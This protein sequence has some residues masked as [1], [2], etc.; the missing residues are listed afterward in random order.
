[1]PSISST[2]IAGTDRA[3]QIDEKVMSAIAAVWGMITDYGDPSS[4][5]VTI[6][7]HLFEDLA[8]IGQPGV[9]R[10]SGSTDENG[11]RIHTATGEEYWL[12]V[13][14]TCTLGGMDSQAAIVISKRTDGGAL[15]D[16]G[17]TY[18]V[19]AAISADTIYHVDAEI[20]NLSVTLSDIDDAIAANQSDI[21]DNAAA[22]L[23]IGVPGVVS[24]GGLGKVGDDFGIDPDNFENTPVAGDVIEYDGARADW[25]TPALQGH[26]SGRFNYTD[27]DLVY[28]DFTCLFNQEELIQLTDPLVSAGVSR[29]SMA[30]TSGQ[31]DVAS[32]GVYE[33]VFSPTFMGTDWSDLTGSGHFCTLKIVHNS[34]IYA[35]DYF[36][37][38]EVLGGQSFTI[39]ALIPVVNDNYG[40]GLYF[41]NESATV[42]SNFQCDITGHATCKRIS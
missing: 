9:L 32:Q 33:V 17:A 19:V 23:T 31:F 1:M 35:A 4:S 15:D 36:R 39:S 27:G 21:A 28:D 6:S 2:E 10:L 29:G 30:V 22:I 3:N 8:G 14:D 37:I 11:L 7:N 18:T 16:T 40:I 38:L 24:L 13:D 12:F 25:A 34:T 26:Y 20:N 5:T 41:K 42:G